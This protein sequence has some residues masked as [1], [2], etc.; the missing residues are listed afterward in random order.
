MST[1]R[2]FII[3]LSFSFLIVQNSCIT[4][5]IPQ[6]N[7]NIEF[8]VV[9][10]MITDQPDSYTIKIFGSIP[11]VEPED[12]VPVTG[13]FVTISDDLGNIFALNEESAGTY[14]TDRF[15]G[16]AGRTY[17]LHIKTNGSFRNHTYESV[18]VTMKPVPPID[19]VYYER[20]TI[21]EQ[22]NIHAREE[23]VR[24]FVNTRD[25]TGQCKFFRW[26]YIE[27]WEIRLP[28]SVP[29]NTVCWVS[30]GSDKIDIK[31]TTSLSE[32][33]IINHPV[34]YV[35]NQTDRLKFK[36]SIL[37][38]QYSLSED[39]YIYW[40]KMQDI[41]GNVGGLY[42]IVP[43]TIPGNLFCVDDP[44]ETVLGYFSVSAEES[45]RIFIMDRF[46]GLFNPYTND[47]CIADTVEN[48]V[49]IPSLN[50][51]VWVIIESF[52]PPYKVITYTRGCA[53][54]TVRGTTKRPYYWDEEK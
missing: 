26:E 35:T 28:Y 45:K 46:E 10:G 17:T 25:R 42:D 7:E 22:D 14:V 54:C 49:F 39:E 6:S 19:S 13:C 34:K 24:I 53:D 31:N 15:Q 12:P 3:F 9:E 20:V 33:V 8:L 43:A 23:G 48:G 36:Y 51:T 38:N 52:Y 27:T 40:E 11:L 21:T 32:D 50:S 16:K 37:V 41:N 2:N 29:K 47:A 1:R 5:F 4:E 30:S 18:P 44:S